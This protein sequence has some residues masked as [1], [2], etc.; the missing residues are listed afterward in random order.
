MT[1]IE[2]KYGNDTNETRPSPV[3]VQPPQPAQS[4]PKPDIRMTVEAPADTASIVENVAPV[5]SPVVT[6]VDKTTTTTHAEFETSESR[7]PPISDQP[8]VLAAG[9]TPEISAQIPAAAISPEISPAISVTVDPAENST[10]AA[11]P[12]MTLLSAAVHATIEHDGSTEAKETQHSSA[13]EQRS[14]VEMAVNVSPAAI[15][16]AEPVAENTAH[17]ETKQVNA[18]EELPTTPTVHHAAAVKPEIPTEPA[19]ATPPLSSKPE[20]VLADRIIPVA[21]SSKRTT[22]MSLT[23]RQITAAITI[24]LLL[25]AAVGAWLLL[26][27]KPEDSSVKPELTLQEHT[28]VETP[29]VVELVPEPAAPVKKAT[30][31]IQQNKPLEKTVVTPKAK[32]AP[33]IVKKDLLL[34]KKLKRIQE[35]RDAAMVKAAAAER[36]REAL[37]AAAIAREQALAQEREKAARLAKEAEKAAQEAK[38]ARAL[39]DEKARQETQQAAKPTAV[40]PETKAPA[41]AAV[42]KPK[43]LFPEPTKFTVPADAK[44]AGQAQST[45]AGTSE[46]TS[47]TTNPCKGPSARFLSTCQ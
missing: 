27:Q 25:S 26:G 6:A 29:P 23:W 16:A 30:P 4:E 3:S 45:D 31:N 37:R 14:T 8:T 15:S 35:E 40:A 9:N 17:V 28:V 32:T 33:V 43:Q 24:S 38:A 7:R 39:A 21:H 34:E 2:K 5:V 19:H 44:P 10:A 46:P 36:E 20:N 42:S 18:R 1:Q 41:K 22:G 12:A 13:P 47:F 11:N